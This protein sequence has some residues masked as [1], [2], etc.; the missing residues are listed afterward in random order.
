MHSKC[1][2]IERGDKAF[3]FRPRFYR[4][5]CVCNLTLNTESVKDLRPTSSAPESL[6]PDTQEAHRKR[7]GDACIVSS[8][9]GSVAAVKSTVLDFFFFLLVAFFFARVGF[10]SLAV[11][12][13]IQTKP[14]PAAASA[15][16]R[17]T[18][19]IFCW[20]RGGILTVKLPRLTASSGTAVIHSDIILK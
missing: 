9:R 11:L 12:L 8:R 14:F 16:S 15:F 20:E 17:V 7:L 18:P 3:K 19:V 4:R 6:L 1:V 2:L 13:L 10:E 5:V